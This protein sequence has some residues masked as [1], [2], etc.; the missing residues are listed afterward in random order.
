MNEVFTKIILAQNN[1]KIQNKPD[2]NE[3]IEKSF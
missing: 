3:P 2:K 1:T